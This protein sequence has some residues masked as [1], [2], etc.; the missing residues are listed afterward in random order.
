M[1][2]HHEYRRYVFAIT[3]HAR[4]RVYLVNF[5]DFPDLLASGRTFPLAFKHACQGLDLLLQSLRR[6]DMA[7]PEPKYRLHLEKP[8]PSCWV[9][10]LNRSWAN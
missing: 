9:A 6:L 10:S 8:L 1:T 2:T 5:P 4:E 3:Y 7:W